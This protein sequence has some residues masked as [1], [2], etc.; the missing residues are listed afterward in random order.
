MNKQIKFFLKVV[1]FFMDKLAIPD[2]FYSLA[3]LLSC[4]AIDGHAH[5]N[6]HLRK[7]DR[8]MPIFL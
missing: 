2:F 6:G 1:V 3:V 4:L 5:V 8:V 7:I